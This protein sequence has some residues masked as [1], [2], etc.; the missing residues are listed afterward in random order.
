MEATC[1]LELL[2]LCLAVLALLGCMCGACII[3]VHVYVL[4]NTGSEVFCC[5]GNVRKQGPVGGA[6]APL[7]I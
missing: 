5:V 2:E 6:H 3:H 4:S 1:M 7:P